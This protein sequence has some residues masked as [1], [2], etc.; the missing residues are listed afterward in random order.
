[1][2]RV[3]IWL[4]LLVFLAQVA[5]DDVEPLPPLPEPTPDYGVWEVQGGQ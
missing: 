1:M 3:A 5:C 2:R 4:V